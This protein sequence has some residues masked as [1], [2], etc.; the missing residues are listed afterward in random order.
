MDVPSDY[1]S[2]LMT[3]ENVDVV[4]FQEAH[5]RTSK[6]LAMRCQVRGFIVIS[7]LNHPQDGIAILYDYCERARSLH[8]QRLEATK[9][10]QADRVLAVYPHPSLYTGDF[11]IALTSYG[12]MKC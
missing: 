3:K 4:L 2:R 6:A 5:T 8:H 1:L 11:N 10:C 12:G 9:S 7:A